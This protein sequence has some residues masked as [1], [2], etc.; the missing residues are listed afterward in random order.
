MEL[1]QL[2]C[3]VTV[4]EELHPI[5]RPRGPPDPGRFGGAARGACEVE[6]GRCGPLVEAR[7]A[8]WY[9][10]EAYSGVRRGYELT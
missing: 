9:L 2:S 1:R 7:N 8:P 6:R 10:P 3:S 5:E 4:G